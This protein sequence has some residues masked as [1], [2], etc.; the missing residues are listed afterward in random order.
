MTHT[1]NSRWSWSVYMCVL[2]KVKGVNR[3]MGK[4]QAR[5]LFNE[6]ASIISGKNAPIT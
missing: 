1:S 3:E 2:Y 5:A 4:C 6:L